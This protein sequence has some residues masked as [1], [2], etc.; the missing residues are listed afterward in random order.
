MVH[1]LWLLPPDKA[2]AS[3]KVPKSKHIPWWA[4]LIKEVMGRATKNSDKEQ[5]VRFGIECK[6]NSSSVSLRGQ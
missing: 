1:G 6:R 4:D 5:R 3:G 2:A